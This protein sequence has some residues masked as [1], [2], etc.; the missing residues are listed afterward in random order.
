MAPFAGLA[1]AGGPPRPDLAAADGLVPF[2]GLRLELWGPALRL[3]GAWNPRRGHLSLGLD[4]HPD[5]WP[6]L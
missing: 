4:A 1:V 2:V 5:W 3:E 6:L